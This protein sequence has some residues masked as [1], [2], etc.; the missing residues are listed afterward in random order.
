MLESPLKALWLGAALTALVL[1]AWVLGAGVDRLGFF[2]FLLRWLHVFAGMIWVGLIWFMNFV[3]LVALQEADEAGKAVLLKS[4]APRTAA[5]FRHASH[6]TIL[7]GLL[8]LATT[9]YLLD[10]WIFATPVFIPPL[11]NLMLWGGTAGGLV[12]WALVHFAVWPSL[13]VVLS[14]ADAGAK[15]AARARIK[16]FARINLVLSLPV[17]FVMVAAGHLY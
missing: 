12:M 13:Q 16:T 1:L 17:T 15:A 2:S 9:G 3:Q 11:R 10:R 6:V 14:D 4:I 7:S 5:A 8:L